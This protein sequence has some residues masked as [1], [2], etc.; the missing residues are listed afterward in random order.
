MDIATVGG[1]DAPKYTVGGGHNIGKWFDKV[2]SYVYI[3][4]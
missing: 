1:E 2:I 4:I 3:Y